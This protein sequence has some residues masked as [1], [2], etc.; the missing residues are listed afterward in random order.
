MSYVFFGNYKD[1][2]GKAHTYTDI[3][4]AAHRGFPNT[5]P[6]IRLDINQEHHQLVDEFLINHP[7][8]EGGSWIREDS[9]ERQEQ[10]ANAIMTSANAVMEA[11]KLNMAEVRELARLLGLNLDSRDDI[12]KAHV[13]KIA[14][15]NPD[16]FMQMWFDE[17]K[18]YRVFMLEAQEAKIIVWEKDTFK[19]GSQTIGIS[20]DQAIK[21]LQDNKDIFALLKS[22]LYNGNGVEMDLV[23]QKQEATKK[24]VKK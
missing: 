3:N 4:G 14:A 11:A 17:D 19:Y 23:E 20:E 12:L 22:Q 13:L 9:I 16:Y 8:V 7:L 5:N 1:K 21:W 24:K 15:E 6:V 18:H 2:T 10:E